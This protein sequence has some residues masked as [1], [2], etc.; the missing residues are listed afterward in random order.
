MTKRDFF[1]IIIKLFGLY[2]LILVVFNYIPANIGFMFRDFQWVALV[3]ILGLTTFVASIYVFLILK[4]D[5]IIDLLKIDKGFDDDQI[6]L[7]DFTTKKLVKFAILLIGGFLVVDYLPS[8]LHN[9]YIAFKEQVTDGRLNF[10]EGIQY[11]T[12]YFFRE[13][14]L[15]G[16]NILIGFLFITNYQRLAD[17]LVRK[18]NKK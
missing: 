17:W 12:S 5:R 9:S 7:G 11:K 3:W 1:R 4:V 14:I 2:S 15:E 18:E 16:I 6:I 10:A 8:F 13:W